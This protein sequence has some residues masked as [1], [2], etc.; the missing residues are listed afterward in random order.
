MLDEQVRGVM[1]SALVSTSK[2]L[3]ISLKELRVQMRL[4]E[5]LEG[6]ECF[7]LK[8]TKKVGEVKWSSILGV[9]AMPF[10]R[11]IV[12]NVTNRL[13][14]LAEQNDIDK[15]EINARVYATDVHGTPKMHLYNGNK[16][17]KAIDIN[18]LI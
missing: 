3:N 11:S 14:E 17:L 12:G 9:K 5:G 6:S 1:R 4:K 10:K 18:E 2:N 7:A 16:P 13:H 8:G 15:N